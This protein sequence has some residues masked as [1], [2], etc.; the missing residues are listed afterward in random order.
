[1]ALLV[2]ISP[3]RTASKARLARAAGMRATV[4]KAPWFGLVS[5]SGPLPDVSLPVRFGLVV[6]LPGHGLPF[7]SRHCCPIRIVSVHLLDAAGQLLRVLFL[8]REGHI[9]A[10]PH[11]VSRAEALILASNQSRSCL[12]PSPGPRCWC[13]ELLQPLRCRPLGRLARRGL[14]H[15]QRG[16]SEN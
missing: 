10:Q 12:G 15:R 16:D 8:D 11:D 14:P 4:P 9:S 3:S 7:P 13:S 1:M 5:V 2:P 6:R